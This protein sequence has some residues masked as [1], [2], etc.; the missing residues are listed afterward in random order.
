MGRYP[1][2][3]CTRRYLDA[4]EPYF[5]KKTHDVMRRGLKAL[6]D[7]FAELKAEGKATTANPER[8]NTKSGGG[9]NSPSIAGMIW[10]LMSE[11]AG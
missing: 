5:E 10:S 1:W 3:T 8:T 11:S 9:D 4:V 2:I 7:A 6:G